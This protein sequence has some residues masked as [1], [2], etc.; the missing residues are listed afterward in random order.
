MYIDELIAHLKKLFIKAEIKSQYWNKKYMASRGPE[1]WGNGHLWS[2]ADKYYQ[3]GYKLQKIIDRLIFIK[4]KI[5]ATSVA[6]INFQ[7]G[8]I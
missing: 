3:L 2:K 4:N 6:E 5:K 1:H 7:K 8:V